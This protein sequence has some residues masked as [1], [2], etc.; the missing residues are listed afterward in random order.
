MTRYFLITLAL[1]VIVPSILWGFAGP[2]ALLALVPSFIIAAT[3]AHVRRP[4][5]PDPK[6]PPR[7]IRPGVLVLGGLFGLASAAGAL[8]VMWAAGQSPSIVVESELSID[9]LPTRVWTE[10]GDPYRRT[11]W[12]LWIADFEP[13]GKAATPAVGAEYRSVLRLERLEVP[14]MQTISA[15][16]AGKTIT[17]QV[18]PQGG[19]ALENMQETVTLEPQANGQTLA[20]FR[21]TYE[22]PSVIG[23]VAER[24]AVRGAVERMAAQTLERLRSVSMGLQ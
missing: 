15:L 1:L 7:V 19:A 5:D 18:Q 21:L 3:I 6:A 8:L 11:A 14:A 12:D 9:A 17:W 13:V 20:R 23:R 24:I 4:A 22:V 2:W 16:D 10:V